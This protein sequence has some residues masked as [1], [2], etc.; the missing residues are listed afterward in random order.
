MKEESNLGTEPQGYLGTGFLYLDVE[1]S[2]KLFVFV[3][4]KNEEKLRYNLD[5][6]I[7]ML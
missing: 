1:F 7:N 4:E 5:S 2:F 6:H 3:Q